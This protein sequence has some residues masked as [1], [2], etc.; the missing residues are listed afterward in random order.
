M[1]Q[2]DVS[3]TPSGGLPLSPA[4]A[5]EL[6]AEFPPLHRK[7]VDRRVV[8]LACVAAGI[9][10]L[11]TLASQA[12]LA[13]IALITNLAFFGRLSV[14][15]SSPADN[16]LG[17][18]LFVV[19]V[20]G[21]IIVGIMARFGSKA[22]R[23]H[24]IP[25]AMEQVLTNQSRIP[26][27]MTLL[28]PISA[29]VAIGTGGPFGAEGPIIATGGALG[30]LVGQ[31]LSTTGSERKALLAAGAAAGMT[32]TFGTPVAAL[33]L[34]V[35]LLLFE[36]RPQS[37]L[38]VAA[39]TIVAATG[40]I[41]I[42]GSAPVFAMPPTAM[43]GVGALVAF[44]LMGAVFGLA[45]VG[46]TRT[47]YA[48]EDA[49]ERLP[50]HWMWW[51]ALGGVAVGVCGWLEPRSLGI[52]YNNLTDLLTGSLTLR[53][54]AV[55]CLAKFVSWAISL[56]SGTSGGTLAPLMTVGGCLGAAL[57][58]SFDAML[59]DAAVDIRLAALVGMA[60]LFAGAARAP[61]ASAMFAFEATREAGTVLP[62]FIGCIIS[63][64][65]SCLAMRHSLMTEKIARRGVATPT[66][67]VPDM[68]DH[69]LVR[70]VATKELVVLRGDDTIEKVRGW[71][72]AG[73]PESR[74]Q[75]FP[76]ID[77]RGT[78]LGVVTR[79][80][81]ALGICGEHHLNDILQRLPIIVYD[82][83]SVREAAE[84][85]LRHDVGRLPVVRRGQADRLVGIITRSDILSAYMRRLHEHQRD[86]SPKTERPPAKPRA[87]ATV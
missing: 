27:R 85:M 87:R 68:L 78:V 43:P 53:A 44:A 20:V 45:A 40:R 86:A 39:A 82:D 65:V 38:P 10:V 29:A 52:G 35:E 18:L 16:H 23:G 74:H 30:S 6:Q 37:L 5:S 62:L 51:P 58:M 83:C 7:T 42:E 56:G 50:I 54:A 57:A 70:E 63:Y 26:A 55:L 1:S 3:P 69:V 59:P 60:A 4:L 19:P 72:A 33:F 80:D 24:G 12:L 25:E 21:G 84:H 11:A 31:I 15:H 47:I 9:G 32:A 41:L 81:M 64:F 28:K 46:A 34:A 67:Y 13:L 48:V 76:V 2:H 61:L 73:T 71:I 79:K 14:E 8:L 17:P 66:E 75:G 77:D 49:F 36:Y 22:I